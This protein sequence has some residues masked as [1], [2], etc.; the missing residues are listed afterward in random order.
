MDG[1]RSWPVWVAG[2]YAV[3]VL[4]TAVWVGLAAGADGGLA[5]VWLI[6]LTLPG[7]PLALVLP[8][9]GVVVLVSL[10]V[11][12]LLQALG[13]WFLLERLR[14]RRSPARS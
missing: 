10:V 4:A 13:T 7:S 1:R 11:V 3:A 8:G 12:G 5:G 2:A 6:L 14:A 9:E